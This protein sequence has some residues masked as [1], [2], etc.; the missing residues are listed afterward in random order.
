VSFVD[1]TA[2]AQ[3]LAAQRMHDP[4]YELSGVIAQLQGRIV[5]MERQV[6]ELQEA[7]TREVERRRKAESLA[8]SIVKNAAEMP[9]TENELAEI[10]RIN[11]ATAVWRKFREP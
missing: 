8:E 6:T 11:M 2:L 7:L 4:L 5:H 9:L 3:R 10:G 1:D